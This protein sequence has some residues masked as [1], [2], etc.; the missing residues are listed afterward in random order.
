MTPLRDLRYVTTI[1][2]LSS[3]L[4]V[5]DSSYGTFAQWFIVVRGSAI[6]RFFEGGRI[7]KLFY[8]YFVSVEM[9]ANL[10][11]YCTFREIQINLFSNSPLVTGMF[12]FGILERYPNIGK[13]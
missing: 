12:R 7:S 3:I 6:F 8:K 11:F 10:Y 9:V 13:Y 1:A 5:F 4:T 2:L